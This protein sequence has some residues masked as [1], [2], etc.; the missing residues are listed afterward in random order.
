MLD[1]LT[2]KYVCFK[3]QSFFFH[4]ECRNR[5][6]YGVQ[7]ILQI[8]VV[9][10]KTIGSIFFLIML[11]FDGSCLNFLTALVCGSAWEGVYSTSTATTKSMTIMRYSLIIN[12]DN[13]DGVGTSRAQHKR[14]IKL[15]CISF[16]SLIAPVVGFLWP[17]S[18]SA[19][20]W[21]WSWL[22]VVS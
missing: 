22:V 18:Q 4:Q 9:A 15:L 21:A 12:H 7:I 13:C 14:V 3:A 1:L 8:D 5:I 20:W 11:F 19:P 6:K 17:R 10:K 2:S 16:R